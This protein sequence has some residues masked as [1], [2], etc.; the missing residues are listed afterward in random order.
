MHA[1]SCIAWSTGSNRMESCL[2]DQTSWRTIPSRRFSWRQG[3]GSSVLG[4]CSWTLNQRL[5]VTCTASKLFCYVEATAN[6]KVITFQTKSGL[7]FTN[8]FFT[9]TCSSLA[10]RTLR[11]TTLEDT[12]LSAASSS[13]WSWTK[14][15]Y[16]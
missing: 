14:F 11:I 2:K 4:Q 5:S 13:T 3:P 10:K 8:D 6:K 16:R 12:T 1:G 9:R 15:D 7:E